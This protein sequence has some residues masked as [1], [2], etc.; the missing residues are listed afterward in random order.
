MRC[1]CDPD[2]LRAVAASCKQFFAHRKNIFVTSAPGQRPAVIAHRGASAT[3][4]ENTVAAF[5]AA[6]AMG[7]DG[8]ELDVRRT[9]DGRMAVCHDAHLPDGRL[10]AATPFSELPGEVCDLAAALDACR[11]LAVVNIEIKN[12]VDDPDF[13][14]DAALATKVADLVA[15]RGERERALVSSFH[16]PTIDRVHQLDPAIPTGWLV[17][18]ASNHDV[19]VGNAA[20]HGHRAIHPHHA[21]VN[22]ALVERAHSAGLTVNVWTCD[23]PDRIRWLASIGVDGIVTNV[24]DV[25][26]AALERS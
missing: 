18:D 7:A 19:V 16:L 14:P 5:E 3:H 22:E 11:P 20:S 23:E 10:L 12:W 13:D 21:F 9:L 1:G 26:L 2:R 15:A 8:V 6:V 17:T 4:P 25:A 24:P